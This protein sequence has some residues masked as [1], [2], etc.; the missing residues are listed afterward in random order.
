MILKKEFFPGIVLTDFLD[1]L[2]IKA[3]AYREF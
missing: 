2:M 3:R 1:M